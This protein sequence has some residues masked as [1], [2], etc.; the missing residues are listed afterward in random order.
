[1][2]SVSSDEVVVYNMPS[3]QKTKFLNMAKQKDTG[4]AALNSRVSQD[5]LKDLGAKRSTPTPQFSV[6]D[7]QL[8]C[9][10]S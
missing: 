4:I 1:M 7:N 8:K 3:D 9:S 2:I 6:K 5:S 10:N